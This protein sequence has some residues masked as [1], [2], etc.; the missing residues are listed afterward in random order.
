MIRRECL[1]SLIKRPHKPLSRKRM[2]API[3]PHVR[4]SR[5][6]YTEAGGAG[7][8]ALQPG[9]TPVNLYNGRCFIDCQ[10]RLRRR[11]DRV[12]K[13]PSTAVQ[14]PA[15]RQQLQYRLKEGALIALGA[16]CLILWMALLTYDQ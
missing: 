16:L 12:L 1:T 5:V 11:N 7:K 13:N 15:W 4:D 8:T 2:H 3:E 9:T 14:A 10:W 6:C